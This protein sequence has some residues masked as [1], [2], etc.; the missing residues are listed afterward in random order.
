MELGSSCGK[1]FPAEAS[2]GVEY[3]KSL[4]GPFP[5]LNC[6]TGGIK[7]DT[8]SNYLACS[9]VVCVGVSWIAPMVFSCDYSEIEERARHAASQATALAKC[10]IPQS[11]SSVAAKR[12]RHR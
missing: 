8:A 2:G 6:P 10:S 11:A 1:F 7:A 4:S 5:V 9:N 3:L 12:P